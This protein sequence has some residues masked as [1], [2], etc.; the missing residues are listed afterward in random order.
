MARVIETPHVLSGTVI[1]PCVVSLDPQSAWTPRGIA[2]H[3]RRQHAACMAPC[4]HDMLT[5][6]VHITIGTHVTN[7]SKVQSP[8]PGPCSQRRPHLVYTF[9]ELTMLYAAAIVTASLN[10]DEMRPMLGYHLGDAQNL[11]SLRD[12]MRNAAYASQQLSEAIR[13]VSNPTARDEW[14]RALVPHDPPHW[15]HQE[16]VSTRGGPMVSNNWGAVCTQRFISLLRPRATCRVILKPSFLAVTHAKWLEVQAQRA[17]E[18]GGDDRDVHTIPGDRRQDR[19][20]LAGDIL[21]L[22]LDQSSYEMKQHDPGQDYGNGTVGHATMPHD[23]RPPTTESILKLYK[24]EVLVMQARKHGHV[25]LAPVGNDPSCSETAQTSAAMHDCS[26][27][28]S[29]CAGLHHGAEAPVS[30]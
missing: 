24:S 28:T 20:I 21:F 27:R 19:Y 3:E 22:T 6:M 1:C 7:M 18:Q 25:P 8:S 26:G 4:Y 2:E 9:D 12:C 30:L 10:M 16:H 17:S 14:Y 15:H 13:C 11:R 5:P 29:R 23:D